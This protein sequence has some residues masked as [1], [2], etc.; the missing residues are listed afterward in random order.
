MRCYRRDFGRR[1]PSQ[2]IHDIRMA[3]WLFER[4]RVEAPLLSNEKLRAMQ[5]H[6]LRKLA[7]AEMSATEILGSPAPVAK[8]SM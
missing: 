6:L 8:C 3:A 5:A 4:L 2:L 7:L 1:D